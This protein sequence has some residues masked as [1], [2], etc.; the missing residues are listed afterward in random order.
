MRLAI[1]FSL[2]PALVTAAPSRRW[3]NDTYPKLP[4]TSNTT[5][6]PF[7][8]ATCSDSFVTA[9]NGKLYLDGKNYTFASFNNVSL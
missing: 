5:L 3:N 2:L 7:E 4:S 6:H 8:L 9:R 1:L